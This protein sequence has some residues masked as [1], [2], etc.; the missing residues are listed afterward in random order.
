MNPKT[1][2]ATSL[3]SF[4]GCPARYAMEQEN[5]LS[6][7]SPPGLFGTALHAALDDYIEALYQPDR[8]PLPHDVEMLL[9]MWNY[10][11]DN[12]LPWGS[13]YREEGADIL[14]KWV[15][16]RELPHEVVEREQKKTF[17]LAIPDID[18]VAQEPQPVTYIID[19]L[20]R[21]PDGTWEIIDYKSQ[22]LNLNPSGM[23]RLIQPALYASAVRREHGITTGQ[24]AVTYDLLRYE[25]VTIYFTQDQIDEFDRFL[26]SL[27]MRIRATEPD[28]AREKLNSK[29]R[30][31]P[32]KAV[33]AT[34]T[35]A[36]DVYW[37]PTMDLSELA[38]I[39]EGLKDATKGIDALVEEIDEVLLNEVKRSESNH[40]D[41]PL[42]ELSAKVTPRTSYD[43]EVL[44]RTV[45]PA[46]VEFLSVGKT[47][48]D[49]E[50]GRKKNN[51]F[52][53]EEIQVIKDSARVTYGEPKVVVTPKTPLDGA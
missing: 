34:L 23:R 39:R 3:E 2:S 53:P 51:R 52:T 8:T 13:D 37:T 48:L 14:R 50:I 11:A 25:P 17:D 1:V 21:L 31:C 9:N 16:T 40:V 45:G 5:R 10:V 32:R 18:G 27:V 44:L 7:E 15:R 29:C 28:A 42:Y 35:K 19:R 36:A 33:C 4:L 24:I 26:T 30:Y 22:Y 20:D 46:A 47:V 6:V 38:A 49:K 12:M 43:P 41:L